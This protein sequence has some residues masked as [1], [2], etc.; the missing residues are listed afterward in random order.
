MKSIYICLFLGV[1]A[2]G[3]SS[4]NE[5]SQQ[6]PALPEH[7]K[8]LENVTVI[9]PQDFPSDNVT[10]HLDQVFTE[11]EDVYLDYAGNIA[12][13]NSGRLFIQTGAEMGQVKLYAF[14]ADG[15][16]IKQIGRY[17]RGPGEF[18][19]IHDIQTDNNRLYVYEDYEVH[20][21]NLSDLSFSNSFVIRMEDLTKDSEIRGLQPGTSFFVQSDSSFY[22]CLSLTFGKEL[23][24]VKTSSIIRL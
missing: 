8:S 4:N 22:S 10:I 21:F 7:V 23:M 17:G 20:A 5:S 3:C 18:E 14:D 9:S 16:F 13:D 11:T 2:I 24:S 1:I 19:R 15:Q 6:V 12:A